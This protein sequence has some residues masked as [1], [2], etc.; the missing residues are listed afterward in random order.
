M[1]RCAWEDQDRW[2]ILRDSWYETPVRVGDVLNLIGSFSLQ[3][4]HP[5]QSQSSGRHRSTPSLK[6]AR[7]GG[8]EGE[9]SESDRHTLAALG[10]DG[11]SLSD[12][13]FDLGAEDEGST[14][15]THECAALEKDAP[16]SPWRGDQS[17]HGMGATAALREPNAVLQG[18]QEEQLAPV[19]A[20]VVD[21]KRHL[22]IL[23]PDL[24]VCLLQ[25]FR[26]RVQCSRR[27]CAR[28]LN[29]SLC[30]GSM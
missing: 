14:A 11:I 2:L 22:V 13:D 29:V 19:M 12:L 26:V 10:L 4:A 30:C 3:S 21:D 6:A 17:E 28:A 1:C 15:G 27:S 9:L 8:R 18:A 25:R 20:C 7:A 24:L 5:L 23:H 16:L